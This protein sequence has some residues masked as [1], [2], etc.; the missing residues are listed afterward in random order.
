M[1]LYEKERMTANDN[2][3]VRYQELKQKQASDTQPAPKSLFEQYQ[4]LKQ[5][6]AVPPTPSKTAGAEATTQPAKQG[7]MASLLAKMTEKQIAPKETLESYKEELRAKVAAVKQPAPPA[8]QPKSKLASLL[9]ELKK[10]HA[11][12]PPIAV[13]P[14]L[15]QSYKEMTA[16]EAN[17]SQLAAIGGGAALGGAAGAGLGYLLPQKDSLESQAAF[18]KRRRMQA[19]LG[20]LGGAIPGGIL[21]SAGY[22]IHK[23]L[24]DPIIG[25]GI[26]QDLQKIKEDGFKGAL[27]KRYMNRLYTE[28]PDVLPAIQAPRDSSPAMRYQ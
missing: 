18:N 20:A 17:F 22:D 6:S 16:K 7:K 28:Q 11:A 19:L 1:N 13:S 10:K 9:D 15:L 27:R 5:V 23:E 21:G 26:K 12:K 8:E 4:A 24:N 14:A 3:F 2:L 25:P